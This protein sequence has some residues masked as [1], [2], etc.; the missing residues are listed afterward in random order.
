MTNGEKYKTAS[1]RKNQ[2][3][4]YCKNNACSDIPCECD[5]VHCAFEWLELEADDMV[6]EIGTMEYGVKRVWSNGYTEYEPMTDYESARYR[7]QFY[8]DEMKDV[9]ASVVVREVG[10][11]KE[12][13]E[14]EAKKCMEV[15]E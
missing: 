12:V 6:T 1:G 5:R 8:K 3:D 10:E 4:H 13:N 9:E 7:V 15:K 2:F 11:W 14:S